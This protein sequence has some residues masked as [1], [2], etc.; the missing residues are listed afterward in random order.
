ML[1]R[2]KSDG[3]MGVASCKVIGQDT[4]LGYERTEIYFVDNSGFGADDELALTFSQF[5]SKVKAGRYYG[6]TEAGQF[7]VYIAEFKRISKS[8][9]EILS[10][11]G[12]LSSKKIKNNTRL[13]IYKNG[14]KILRLHSTDIIKWQGNKIILNS[15]GWNTMTTRARFNEFLPQGLNVIRRKGITWIVDNRKINLTGEY[16]FFDGIEL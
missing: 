8:R 11:Q 5:L 4:P 14:D 1:Y 3:D 6:I 2:A 12:I 9:A 7:Q 10:E 15:G 16:K 13:T